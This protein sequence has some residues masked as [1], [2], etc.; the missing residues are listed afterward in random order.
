M[1][2]INEYGDIVTPSSMTAGNLVQ[3]L[4]IKG[5]TSQVRDLQRALNSSLLDNL[6]KRDRKRVMQALA[7]AILVGQVT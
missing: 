1:K 4:V 5:R 2:I 6:P 3:A 7:L